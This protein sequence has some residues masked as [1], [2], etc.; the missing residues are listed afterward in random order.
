MKQILMI[1]VSPRG[2]DSARISIRID[3]ARSERGML[4]RSR[5]HV[6]KS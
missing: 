3:P 1:E 4:E 5:S 2:K 6:V